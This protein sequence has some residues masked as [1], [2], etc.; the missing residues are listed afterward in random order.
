MAC[1]VPGQ[2]GVRGFGLRLGVFDSISTGDGAHMCTAVTRD[3]DNVTASDVTAT[4]SRGA[5]ATIGARAVLAVRGEYTR[6]AALSTN[7]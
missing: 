3:A 6:A 2:D 1:R 7:Q 4:R 5:D